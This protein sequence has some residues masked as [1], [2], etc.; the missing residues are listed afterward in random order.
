MK[1]EAP[2]P[3]AFLS[4]DFGFF[5]C[6]PFF[7]FAVGSQ[8]SPKPNHMITA[9]L[10]DDEPES[11]QVNHS[12]IN[13]FCPNV[14]VLGAYNDPVEGM[15]ALKK[16]KPDL[17]LLDIEMPGMTGLELLQRMPDAEFEVIFVTAYNQYAL[18]AIKL[19][20]ID[21]LLKPVDPTELE[22]A[23]QKVGQR[24]KNK[25]TIEQVDVLI[26]LMGKEENK[27]GIHQNHKIALPTFD[28]IVY[29]EM[30]C[31][32][33]VEAEK[34]Y[35]NFHFLDRKPLLIAKNIGIYEESLDGYD[36]M[37]VHRSHIVNL[38][39]VTEFLRH[40]GGGLKMKNGD[41][42]EISGQKREEILRRMER[43]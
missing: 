32:L 17:A 2:E 35:C 39:H 24:L 16:D 34:N 38:R 29:A 23:M 3:A 4:Y 36:F 13:M 15:E 10:I 41:V 11:L 5:L 1:E 9:I 19:S 37:R 43:I 25:R 14:K 7:N 6:L 21:Y 18:N 31:V 8:P 33:R 12:M 42:V 22:N 28:S 30:S 26:N 20:A 27:H 40:D